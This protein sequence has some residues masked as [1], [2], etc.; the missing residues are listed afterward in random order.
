ML[1][2]KESLDQLGNLVVAMHCHGHVDTPSAHKAVLAKLS[3]AIDSQV[4]LCTHAGLAAV[5]NGA[6]LLL[7]CLICLRRRGGVGWRC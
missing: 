7:L 5:L 3:L 2:L 6:G 4:R 1:L